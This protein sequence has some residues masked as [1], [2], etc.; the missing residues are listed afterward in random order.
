MGLLGGDSKGQIFS[1]DLLLALIPIV[2]IIGMATADMDNILNLMQGA[3]FQSSTERAAS[4]TV[5]AL[6]ETSGTPIDWEFT[7]NPKV[8][9]LAH[10]DDIKKV[11]VEGTTDPIKLASLNESQVQDM[12]GNNYGFF[13]NMT[14]VGDNYT[15]KTLGTYNN[16][17]NNVVRV[18][19]FVL[20]GY[21]NIVSSAK[22]LLRYNPGP[23]RVYTSPPDPFPTNKNYLDVF[24]Y[25]A[26]VVNRG[27]DS[28]TVEINNNRVVSPNDFHGQATRYANIT[29]PV[30][31]QFLYN[32]TYFMNNTVTV[33][34]ASNPWSSLD[35]YI[36][37]V[38]KGTPQSEVNLD[39][40]EPKRYRFQFYLWVK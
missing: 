31:P 7:G 19:R 35:V 15:I 13:I 1:I 27:Y 29:K 39:N 10:Y 32:E 5:H 17:A 36:V 2:L 18:E 14:R 4:D 21:L 20:Y 22:D 8:A 23:P 3:V 9:G 16:S 11:P 37:Q 26:L 24:D 25:W 38:P 30:D 6:L 40:V 28:A 33:R 34:G 12:I